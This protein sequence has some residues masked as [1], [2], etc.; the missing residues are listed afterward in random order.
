[1]PRGSIKK[2]DHRGLEGATYDCLLELD[3]E[4][5]Y[6]KNDF[7]AECAVQYGKATGH[8]I[9]QNGEYA[10]PRVSQTVNRVLKQEGWKTVTKL[11]PIPGLLTPKGKRV[12]RSVRY[13]RWG[14][15]K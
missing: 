9:A 13:I 8:I 1:M 6:V 11:V 14:N 4:K 12:T 15:K 7:Y 3:L 10:I 5:E 2:I